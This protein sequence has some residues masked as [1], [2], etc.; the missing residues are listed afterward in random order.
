MQPPLVAWPELSGLPPLGTLPPLVKRPGLPLRRAPGARLGPT[1]GSRLSRGDVSASRVLGVRVRAPR[2]PRAG[3]GRLGGP[4]GVCS[5][6]SC[7]R[8]P[9]AWRRWVVLHGDLRPLCFVAVGV[10][11]EILEASTDVVAEL[12]ADLDNAHFTAADFDRKHRARVAK[13]WAAGV[14]GQ[15]D[16]VLAQLGVGTWANGAVAPC[17]WGNLRK[18]R[19]HRFKNPWTQ[20]ELEAAIDRNGLRRPEDAPLGALAQ[21]REA[22]K[23]PLA[24]APAPGTPAPLPAV[25]AGGPSQPGAASAAASRGCGG[26]HGAAAPGGVGASPRVAVP[27]CRHDSPWGSTR[28]LPAPLAR[29]T[30]LPP[31]P[32][33]LSLPV[34][35]PGSCIAATGWRVWTFAAR[36]APSRQHRKSDGWEW[37]CPGDRWGDRRPSAAR[38]GDV[39][40]G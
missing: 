36:C 3:G 31:W 11:P 18:G 32:P 15:A 17:G 1:P 33:G 39:P 19:V 16:F 23:A 26:N 5:F 8:D 6:T 28:W 37:P 4:P 13:V 14:P 20:A 10:D 7:E 2:V 24:D 27:M 29:P 34:T 35:S 40:P 25:G 22:A 38:P 9:E 21:A 12:R 30:G